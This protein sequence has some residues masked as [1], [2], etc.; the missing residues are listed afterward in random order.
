MNPRK[1]GLAIPAGA[2]NVT[3]ANVAGLKQ[4]V[5]DAR[6][7]TAR[8]IVGFIGDST[9]FGTGSSPGTNVANALWAAGPTPQLAKTLTGIGIPTNCNTLMGFGVLTMNNYAGASNYDGLRVTAGTWNASTSTFGGLGATIAVT[10][11]QFTFAPKDTAG[12]AQSANRATIISKNPSAGRSILVR[13]NSATAL[14]ISNDNSKADDVPRSDT[15]SFTA[16]TAMG[17]QAGS[18]AAV[19]FIGIMTYLNTE[20]A[21]TLVSGGWPGSAAADWNVNPTTF[22]PIMVIP[23]LGMSHCFIELTINDENDSV[24]HITAYKASIQ[25]LIDACVSAGVTVTLVVGGPSAPNPPEATHQTLAIQMTYWQALY[26]LA[27]LNNLSLLDLNIAIGSY[28]YAN[29]IGIMWDVS[30]L[31][32]TGYAVNKAQAF[33]NF[34]VYAAALP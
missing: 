22:G 21:M 10:G 13:A 30:H 20:T 28:A 9:R 25:A 34:I 11:S 33:S 19:G 8:R 16:T 15:A 4:A 26:D 23:V 27:T 31:T 2:F 5:R 24:V 3:S 14:T 7:G 12:L 32:A 17:L 18:A 6:S 29:S 1:G